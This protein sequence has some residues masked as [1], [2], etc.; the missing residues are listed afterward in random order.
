MAGFVASGATFTFNGINATITRMSVTTPTA[1]IVNMTPAG[2]D[3]SYIVMVPTGAWSGG[4]IEV[5]F[6]YQ[7][8]GT[9]PQTAVGQVGVARF[10]SPKLTVQR[11]VV[12]ESATTEVATGDIVRGTLRFLMT[13]YA[14]T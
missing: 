6:L 13:D 4:S 5:D 14:G 3:P 8:N 2:A 12:L 10:A 9:D 7:A 11:R 1:E